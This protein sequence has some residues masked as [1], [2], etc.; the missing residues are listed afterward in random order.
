MTSESEFTLQDK[1][2]VLKLAK[3]VDLS[4]L[5][6]LLRTY[7]KDHKGIPTWG[8]LSKILST[9]ELDQVQTTI[10]EFIQRKS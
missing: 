1:Y 5:L 3:Q 8:E 2:L 4:K 9:V 6:K 10:G 7:Q